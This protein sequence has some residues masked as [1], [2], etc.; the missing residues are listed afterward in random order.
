MFAHVEAPC[1]PLL[2]TSLPCLTPGTPLAPFPGSLPWLLFHP[3]TDPCHFM[4]TLSPSTHACAQFPPHPTRSPKLLPAGSLNRQPC[5]PFPPQTPVPE[6][7]RVQPQCHLLLSS[8]ECGGA[9]PPAQ[10]PLCLHPALLSLFPREPVFSIFFSS[11]LPGG[12][13]PHGALMRILPA[14]KPPL[15]PFGLFLIS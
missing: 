15:T 12:Q 11:L 5:F 2:S 1:L 14:W 9:R 6:S 8:R 10:H 13:G 7:H 4:H 3:P